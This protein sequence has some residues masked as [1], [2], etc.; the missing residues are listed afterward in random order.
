[1]ELQQ[2]FEKMIEIRNA[3]TLFHNDMAENVHFD[4]QKKALMASRAL[5]RELVRQMYYWGTHEK[6]PEIFE[7]LTEENFIP[8][9]SEV[10]QSIDDVLANRTR[11][12]GRS[13]YPDK[14]MQPL[15]DH[16]A[17]ATMRETYDEVEANHYVTG[18]SLLSAESFSP[19]DITD[20]ACFVDKDGQELAREIL[21]EQSAIQSMAASMEHFDANE[22]NLTDGLAPQLNDNTANLVAALQN[23]VFIEQGR[24]MLPSYR[25][26]YYNLWRIKHLK[27][28]SKRFTGKRNAQYIARLDNVNSYIK[29]DT[30]PLYSRAAGTIVHEIDKIK[31]EILH[32]MLAKY[33]TRRSVML[34][35]KSLADVAKTMSEIKLIATVKQAQDKEVKERFPTERAKDAA[36]ERRR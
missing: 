30:V 9:A 11:A 16:I 29:R 35:C 5:C 7:Q 10:K 27:C 23:R 36:Q 1:M 26:T 13:A 24:D 4:E 20:L 21:E 8:Y 31:Q 28:L 6:A 2:A 32:E 33:L 15:I 14:E 22:L 3:Q 18:V 19:S 17:H 25:G 12:D 34:G